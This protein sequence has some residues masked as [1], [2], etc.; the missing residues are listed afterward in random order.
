[1][2][3]AEAEALIMPKFGNLSVG[4]EGGRTGGDIEAGSASGEV[5]DVFKSI[6]TECKVCMHN[7]MVRYQ[8]LLLLQCEFF[9]V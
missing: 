8:V 3:T 9:V 4:E 7:R 5:E 1:M 6:D 2:S